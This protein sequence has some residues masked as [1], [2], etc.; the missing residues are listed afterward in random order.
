MG[1]LIG[2]PGVVMG[3]VGLAVGGLCL[4]WLACNSAERVSLKLPARLLLFS[5]VVC[6]TGYLLT[7]TGR[8]N[9]RLL[10][11]WLR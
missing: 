8:A 1:G 6:V 9:L 3:V 4:F 2:S 7:P 10:V 11:G 5:L